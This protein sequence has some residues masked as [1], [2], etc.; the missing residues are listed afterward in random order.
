MAAL[1][2]L[3]L[4]RR[5]VPLLGTRRLWPKLRRTRDM[6]RLESSLLC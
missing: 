5:H 6:A 4:D 1:D 2:P 3:A